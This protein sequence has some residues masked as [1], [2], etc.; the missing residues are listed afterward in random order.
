MKPLEEMSDEELAIAEIYAHLDGI[1]NNIQRMTSGNY[2]HHI[3]SIRLSVSIIKNRLEK[4]GIKL[5][6]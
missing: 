4:I 2:M 5:E 1:D 3:Y 6:D